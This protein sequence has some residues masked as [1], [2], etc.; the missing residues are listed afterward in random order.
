LNI[1]ERLELKALRDDVRRM[2]EAQR[3]HERLANNLVQCITELRA[4][5]DALEAKRG[6]GR[7]RRDT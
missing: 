5:L 6:P 3:D 1:G 2:Q 7:L 4:R